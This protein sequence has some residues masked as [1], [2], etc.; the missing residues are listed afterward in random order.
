MLLPGVIL[1]ASA[2]LMPAGT[3]NLWGNWTICHVWSSH[4]TPVMVKGAQTEPVL[5]WASQEAP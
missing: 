5:H 1:G 3:G 2:D 4:L